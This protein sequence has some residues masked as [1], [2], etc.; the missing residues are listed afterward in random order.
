MVRKKVFFCRECGHQAPRWMGRCPGC[1]SWNTLVEEREQQAGGIRKAAAGGEGPRPITQVSALSEERFSTRIAE[2]D[3]VMG[4]GIVPGS[5]ILLGGDPGIGKSTLLL[6]VAGQVASNQGKVIYVSGEE[7]LSQVK[8]RAERLG[9]NKESVY[10]ATETRITTIE[11]YMRDLTPV[12]VIVDSIQ[13]MFHPEVASAPGSVSQ[14]RECTYALMQVAKGSQVSVMVSGHV[15]KE[16]MLAGPRVL[17]HMVDVVLYLEG[18]RHQGYRL[19]RGVKNR[20]GSTNEVGVFEMRGTGM[21]EVLNPSALFMVSGQGGEVPG[22]VVV[23]TMEGTRPL[24]VEIQALVCPTAFGMP[25]RMTTGVDPGR[26]SLIMA[27]LEKRVGLQMGSYDAYVNV[28]GGV[29][30]DEPAVDLGVAVALA[31]SFKDCPTE[32]GMAVMGEVGLTGEI[33]SV[34]GVQ[35]R[36][37]EAGQLGFTRCLVPAADAGLVEV[38]G[39]EVEGVSTVSSAIERALVW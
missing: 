6:Q 20:F 24:L 4:G 1:G 15:T 19:L 31:S 39:I 37:S 36:V 14:V 28:V 33:R 16:G 13:T 38:A 2:F 29:K 5:L 17:E 23:P 7:S 11:E 21:E 30:I 32:K 9:I 10:L 12:L 35:K 27:V 3:R 22:S 34:P 26:S 18:Q 25:K 8:L